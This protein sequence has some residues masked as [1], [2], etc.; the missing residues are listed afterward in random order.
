MDLKSNSSSV[1]IQKDNDSDESSDVDVRNRTQTAD[2][3]RSK[4]SPEAT[5]KDHNSSINPSSPYMI[6]NDPLENLIDNGRF[7]YYD[8]K[9]FRNEQSIGRSCQLEKY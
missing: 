1:S 5:Q 3:S 6:N 7:T 8:C 4:L 9:E 2:E